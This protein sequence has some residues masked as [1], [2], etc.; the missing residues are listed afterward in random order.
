MQPQS[1]PGTPTPDVGAPREWWSQ[2][3]VPKGLS[4]VS[5]LGLDTLGDLQSRLT[6]ARRDLVTR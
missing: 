4:P 3:Q 5:T 1:G 6:S 2:A